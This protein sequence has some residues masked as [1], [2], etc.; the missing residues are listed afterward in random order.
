MALRTLDSRGSWEVRT[1]ARSHPPRVDE[2]E[3]VDSVELLEVR[4][5]LLG[6]LEQ[7][8]GELD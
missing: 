1:L 3:E 2:R 4:H 5:H 8:G 6:V 7:D